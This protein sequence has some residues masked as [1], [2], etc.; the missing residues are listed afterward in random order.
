LKKSFK[1]SYG[2][3]FSL[4]IHDQD[5][6][7]RLNSISRSA[8]IELISY[9]ISESLY[10]EST[11]LSAKAQNV[12]NSLGEKAEGV[13]K[14]LRVSSLENIHEISTK[15]GHDL[16]IRYRKSSHDI[17]A[18]AKFDRNTAEVLQATPSNETIDLSIIV[19]RLN[20]HTGNGRLQIEGQDE[21]TAFGF[22]IKYKEVNIR[23]KK[24]FSENLDHNNG[25]ER[26]KWKYLRISTTPIRLR[27]GKIVKY[28]VKGFYED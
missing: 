26:D 23:A 11:P 13:V 17:T 9:F 2:H 12:L 8:F 25:L 16:K 5:L 21:T 20:I 28:V 6:S 22:G 1:G 14:Q 24:L 10:M 18:I 15:F 4:D 3:T 27:D 7:K 19:T